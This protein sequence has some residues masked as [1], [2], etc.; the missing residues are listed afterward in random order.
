[1]IPVDDLPVIPF[2]PE[3]DFEK[4]M[5][6]YSYIRELKRLSVIERKMIS[7]LQSKVNQLQQQLNDSQKVF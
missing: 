2:R 7:E 4:L 1:M 5:F 6:A 3:T